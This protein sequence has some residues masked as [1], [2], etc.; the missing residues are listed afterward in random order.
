MGH[1]SDKAKQPDLRDGKTR[2]AV[3][4]GLDERQAGAEPE[5]VAPK[6]Q[7]HMLRPGLGG[8]VPDG[9]ATKSS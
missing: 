6:P 4:T 2:G 7:G 9:Q 1:S 8:K 5:R 3:S